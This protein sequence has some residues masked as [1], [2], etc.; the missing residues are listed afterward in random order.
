MGG[1]HEKKIL[2]LVALMLFGGLAAGRLNAQMKHSGN[3]GKCDFTILGNQVICP[4]TGDKF[5]ITKNSPQ[6]EYKG[7]TYFFCCP[8][9][10]A[11][12][13]ANPEKYLKGGSEKQMQ[14]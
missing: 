14:M 10:P 6:M 13:K 3:T 12:F 11:K 5:V 1:K 2:M 9:C 8:G 7:K 4:V